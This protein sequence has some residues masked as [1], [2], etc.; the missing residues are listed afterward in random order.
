[1]SDGN[2]G[3]DKAAVIDLVDNPLI[4]DA[5]EVSVPAPAYDPL[6]FTIKQ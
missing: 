1:M 5:D 3:N 4:A 2:D 6:D